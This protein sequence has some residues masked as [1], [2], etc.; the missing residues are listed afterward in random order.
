MR[1]DN[2]R[3]V[4]G[5][6]GRRVSAPFTASRWPPGRS[7]LGMTMMEVLLGI[8]VAAIMVGVSLPFVKNVLAAYDLSA[9]VAA[10]SG[11][12]QSTRYQ[13]IATGCPYEI[14]F[15][16]ATTTYQVSYEALTGTPPACAATFS[17]LG[18]AIPW[19]NA[20]NISVSPATTLQFSPNGSVTAAVGSMVFSLTNGT[21]IETITI[22]GVGNVSVS[23]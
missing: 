16:P 2:V 14:A 3:C 18:N 10:V 23:P 15:S 1:A 21:Q 19:S 9:A 22:S 4:A 11:A 5:R 13:A 12:V 6:P 20:G 8:A 17:D 7:A